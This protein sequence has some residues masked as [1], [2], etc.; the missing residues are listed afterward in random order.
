MC[1]RTKIIAWAL[2]LCA[3]MPALAQPRGADE[4]VAAFLERHGLLEALAHHLESELRLTPKQEREE[5]A[6]RIGDVYTRLLERGG[7][8]ERVREWESSAKRI[9]GELPEADTIA[10]RLSLARA[11]FVRAESLA[12]RWRIRDLG[13]DQLEPLVES[14][15][16]VQEELQRL[17]T[18]SHDQ[19]RRYERLEESGGRGDSR[20][21][22]DRLADTRR[23]RSLANYFRAWSLYYL[24]ELRPD[25][26]SA[27]AGEAM[28]CFG[29]LLNAEPGRA[30]TVERLPE[31]LLRYEHV[32]RAAIGMG[33]CEAIRGRSEESLAWFEA[34]DAAPDLAP[35][36]VDQLP[37]RRLTALAHLGKWHESLDLVRQIRTG[38]DGND[39]PMRTALARSLAVRACETPPRAGASSTILALRRLAVADLIARGEVGHVLA[40]AKTFP[41]Q[42][43]ALGTQG[44]LHH[45]LAALP[46]YD[47]ARTV[48]ARAGNP[49]DPTADPG[50]RDRYRLALDRFDAALGAP[51]A[52]DFA[53][54]IPG[55]ELLAAFS[56]FYSSQSS[57]QFTA[58]AERF[59]L[60]SAGQPDP[61]RASGALWMALRAYESAAAFAPGDEAVSRAL[62]AITAEFLDRFPDHDR[63]AAIV[64]RRATRDG[65]PR[66]EAIADLLLVPASSEVYPLARRYAERLLYEDFLAAP[67]SDRAWRASRHL[68]VAEELLQLDRAEAYAGIEDVAA[69]TLDIAR[70]MLSTSL[71]VATPDPG[72]AARVLDTARAVLASNPRD[73]A[74]LREELAYRHGQVLLA[75]NRLEEAEA[76]FAQLSE[77]SERFRAASDR[78][79]YEHSARVW[80]GDPSSVRFAER[81]ARIGWRVIRRLAPIESIAQ[82]TVLEPDIAFLYATVAEA[83]RALWDATADPEARD[84][85]V[86]LFRVLREADPNNLTV[87]ESS[88]R[89]AEST[90]DLDLAIEC[91]R[92]LLAGLPRDEPTRF[93]ALFRLTSVLSETDPARAL[94]VLSQ[95]RVLTP[96]I[97]PEPWRTRLLELEGQIRSSVGSGDTP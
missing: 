73:D 3:A 56:M 74:A 37:E 34:V 44:F 12:E 76:A 63:A 40:L 90:G 35:A 29:W 95:H 42:V 83:S 23:S 53:T 57:E 52:A 75:S 87:L 70:R 81:T 68:D 25:G 8:P 80:R 45:Y 39:A 84:D 20:L 59:Q 91:Y 67:A 4:E 82:D 36:L 77:R 49:D 7:T 10:L 38:I 26:A 15:S 69:R 48:H 71:D 72:R 55:L 6:V 31:Q 58:A 1:P 9:L 24:A 18:L 33:L 79:L 78:Q 22:S 30:P 17:A 64:V 60:A 62:E 51:D 41:E 97:G 96:D 93:E 89:L 65:A 85:A 2:A 46:E 61:D 27:R 43:R 16:R 32:A 21:L 13:D 14:L 86:R 92:R 50:V 5:L 66:S 88:A 28:V 47:A 11:E 19:V 94:E 54:A